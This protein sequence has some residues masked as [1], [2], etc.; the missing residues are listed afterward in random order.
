[1][2]KVISTLIVIALGCLSSYVVTHCAVVTICETKCCPEL[3]TMGAALTLMMV[4]YFLI[5]TVK[6]IW[7]GG[8]E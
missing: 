6:F 3:L 7:K 8:Q 5:D 1:M 2:E 4:F